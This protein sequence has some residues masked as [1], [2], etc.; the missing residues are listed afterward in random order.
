M[1]RIQTTLKQ[2]ATKTNTALWVI[3]KDY[4]LSHLLSA[5]FKVPLFDDSLVHYI[6]THRL[7][8]C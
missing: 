6:N 2:K 7:S 1:N 8:T 3:E 5:I 4:A